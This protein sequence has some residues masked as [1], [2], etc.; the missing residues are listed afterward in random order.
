MKFG[1]VKTSLIDYPG[2]VAAVLFT[3]GC[4][5]RCPYCHNP[6]LVLPPPPEDMLDAEEALAFLHA[7]RRVLEGVCV[8]GGEPLLYTGLPEF[9]REIRALGYKIKIDT[10]G[11]LPQALKTLSVD[12]IAM[13]IKTLP[14]KY[15]A[16]L[17]LS[18]NPEKGAGNLAAALRESIAYIT[19]SGIDHEFR[20]TAA[21]GIFLEE[22][23]PQ[24]ARLLQGSRHYILTGMRPGVTLDAEY[25]KTTPYPEETLARICAA[26]R[27]AG[28]DCS[29]RGKSGS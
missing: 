6:N 18:D 16:L 27:D 29:I 24:L 19:G 8:S 22:D 28:L 7:R 3:H 23:I 14:E 15:A 10:N 5:L 26:F 1:L 13:D 2:V 9:L 21:P 17:P 4:N 11:S 25:G 20:T 12:Y